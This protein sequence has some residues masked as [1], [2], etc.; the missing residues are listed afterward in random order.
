MDRKTCYGILDKV[1]PIGPE[2]LRE[3]VTECF[4]CPERV[5]CLKAALSTREGIEMKAEMLDRHA[6]NGFINRLR[7]WSQKKELSRLMKKERKKRK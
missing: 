3:I 2:G 4:Q 6:A 7:R 5:P 1:F